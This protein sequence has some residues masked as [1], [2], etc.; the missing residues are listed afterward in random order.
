VAKNG[1]SQT[2]AGYRSVGVTLAA[3]PSLFSCPPSHFDLNLGEAFLPDRSTHL[4]EKD[5]CI[6]LFEE[7]GSPCPQKRKPSGPWFTYFVAPLNKSPPKASNSSPVSRALPGASSPLR[8][9]LLPHPLLI[10]RVM[11]THP[12]PLVEPHPLPLVEPACASSP[13]LIRTSNSSSGL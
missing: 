4:Y 13:H 2:A 11:L 9:S 10:S 3:R 8:S 7:R 12:L 1:N 6:F 5:L